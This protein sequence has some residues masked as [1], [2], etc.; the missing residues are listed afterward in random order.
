MLSSPPDWQGRGHLKDGAGGSLGFLKAVLFSGSV[1]EEWRCLYMGKGCW[2]SS[3][4]AVWRGESLAVVDR[5]VVGS[6]SGIIPVPQ[7]CIGL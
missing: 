5:W 2:Q 3:V 1:K 6:A 7:E 4:P